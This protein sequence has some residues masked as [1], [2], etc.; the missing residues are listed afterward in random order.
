MPKRTDIHK[1]MLLGAGP[2]VIGQGCEFDYSGVQACKAL[3]K[4]GYELVLLNSNPATVMTDPEFADRTYLEPMTAEYLHEIIRRERPDALLPTLGGQTALNLAMEAY[5]SGVLKRYHVELIGA[6]AEA[7]SRAEDRRLFKATMDSIGIRSANSESAHSMKEALVIA[8]AIG[9]W[10]LIVRPGF[11]LGGSGGGIAH[12]EEEF[13]T[14]VERG[15]EMSLNHEVLIEESLLGWKEYEMEVMCDKRGTSVIVCSIENLDP[16]GVHTGD[17]ITVAPA[18]T[19]TDRE[20]QAM[21]TDSLKVME[22]IGIQTGGSNVQWA[23]NPLNG[24]RL[25]IEMNPRVS[26][27][28]ALAS[29]ATGFPIAKIAALL[30]VGYT[31]DELL[32]DITK[33]T[34]ACF[35]PVLDYVVVKMPRFTF[36]KFPAANSTLGTQ[37]KAVGEAM[38]IGRNFNQA[39]QKAVRSLE[40]GHFGFGLE[41][42]QEHFEALD[43]ETVAAELARPNADRVYYLHAALKRGWPL[44]HIAELTRIDL[45]YLR[46]L[47]ELVAFEKN[48]T[49]TPEILRKAKEMGYSDRQ[50]AYA[51]KSDELAVR[52]RRKALGIL[53]VYGTVDTCAGEFAAS[54]PYYYST[55]AEY[56]EPVHSNS[57]KKK[58][59]ILGGGPNRIGQGIEFD[60]CCV[61]AVFALKAA[62]YETI[63][64]NSNPETVST[65]YDTADHLYFEPLTF[66]DVLNVYERE[67]CDGV[68]VQL[69]GQTPLN[70]ASSLEQAGV[71]IIGTPPADIDA[72]DDRGIFK[73]IAKA[74][75]V[76]QPASG[77]A[78]TTEDACRIAAEIGYPVLVRPSFVLGGRAMAIVNQETTLRSYMV[79]ATEVSEG[80]PIL[81]DKF[82]S[83]AQELDVDCLSDGHDTVIGAIMEHVEQAGIHSGDS[84]CSIPPR[85]LPQTVLDE[86]QTAS[87]R[88]ARELHVVG[89][90][91][92]QFAV[93]HGVLYVIEVNPRASRTVPFASKVT[94]APLA[95]Y[96]ALLMTG[97]TLKELG[98]TKS[99]KI[100]Y[101]AFKEAVFPFVKFPGVD[102]TLS[103]EMKSTGEVM[104]IDFDEASAYLKSQDAAGNRIPRS[105]GVFLSIRDADKQAALPFLQ[106]LAKHDFEFYATAGTGE[107]LYANGIQ[108]HAVFR[109]S[110]GRPNLR[111]LII[112]KKIG[113]IV[114]IPDIGDDG[115][116]MRSFAIE[117]G[118]P[119]TTTTAALQ[120]A[121]EGL[122]NSVVDAGRVDVCS[123]QEYHR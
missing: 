14:I 116:K 106:Q 104:G 7:I 36:E 21:R 94:G 71:K 30:A 38:S 48:I 47:A 24:E 96:A 57:G 107:L 88:L 109:L 72:A 113:W 41:P 61:H 92:I 102:I 76:R 101:S 16:M 66:E 8:K 20:Y 83:D 115:A 17:S 3:K 80:H 100:H 98:F 59:M 121:T 110:A 42:K 43:D 32:N 95:K 52:A 28:S 73:G 27:S 35:E 108:S 10:P 46:K 70:L 55:Y 11:T 67:Q 75:G 56:D 82:L 120:M 105:G 37:M 15:L 34:P 97:A 9:K 74:A 18:M 99:P 26:R 84:A 33:H 122:V 69:G 85:D 93:Q 68:I 111:D 123:L 51:L 19:L 4:E 90:M 60:C 81:I 44:E 62:G 12:S 89:L 64:V 87:C 40:T 23:V 1:I 86:I 103:P 119:I 114:N 65:D 63:M 117:F 58:I 13:R 118:L 2:V 49:D 50:L 77:M 6:N 53:P 39:F 5:H 112:E 22:A 91:N 25:I 45:F 29:K 54:T 78:S 31:L 79:E